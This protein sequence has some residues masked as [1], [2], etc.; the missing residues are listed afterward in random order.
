MKPLLSTLE[1]QTATAHVIKQDGNALTNLIERK[2]AEKKSR[3]SIHLID[4]ALTTWHLEKIKDRKAQIAALYELF[5][6][7]NRWLKS[8]KEKTTP[9]PSTTK[10][11]RVVRALQND[12]QDNLAELLPAFA[13][14]QRR[15]AQGINPHA[16]GLHGV[17][18]NERRIYLERNK[19]SAPSATKFDI[20]LGDEQ[21]NK[22]F[23]GK[24][25]HDLTE[26]EFSKLAQTLSSKYNVLFMNKIQRLDYLVYV[27]SDDEGKLYKSD[28]Q[29]LD[30]T[31]NQSTW[32]PTS[33]WLWTMDRH[34]NLYVLEQDY[35]NAQTKTQV[36]HS[37][38]SA[39]REIICGGVMKVLQGKIVEIDNSSGH[40]KPD[41]TRLLVALESL[42]SEGCDL[43]TATISVY[44]AKTNL[45]NNIGPDVYTGLIEFKQTI[46]RPRSRNV[47]TPPRPVIP[48][49]I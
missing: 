10:R 27:N 12:V 28:G 36:N 6:T 15:A 24:E 41:P 1:F 34:S 4:E 46:L 48:V 42:Q 5:K 21:S 47:F 39:G 19:V 43:S 33:S 32:A 11:I 35:L 30:T 25:L 44:S 23:P 17:Y 29:V 8:R 37:S 20:Y 3:G 49:R 22:L 18:G 16:H 45:A 14:F 40:Y 9:T 7:C 31:Q 26:I 13:I 38:V 2:I